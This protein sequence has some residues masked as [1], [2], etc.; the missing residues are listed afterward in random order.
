VRVAD[1]GATLLWPDYI[2][3]W[4]FNTMGMAVHMTGSFMS[5]F[6]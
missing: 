2:G 5:G 3:N 4:M 6:E 1:G